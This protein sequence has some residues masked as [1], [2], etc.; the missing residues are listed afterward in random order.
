MFF[1][2]YLSYSGDNKCIISLIFYII[3]MQNQNVTSKQL[4]IF[5]VG[6]GTWLKISLSLYRWR[7]AYVTVVECGV[8]GREQLCCDEQHLMHIIKRENETPV[9]TLAWGEERGREA[10]TNLRQRKNITH[11]VREMTLFIEQN[12]HLDKKLNEDRECEDNV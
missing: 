1:L 3:L 8:R 12:L 7:G 2:I 4:F 11:Q 9:L 10:A 5:R 6:G